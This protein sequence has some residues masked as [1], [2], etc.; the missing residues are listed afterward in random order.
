MTNYQHILI[1][2]DLS[3]ESSI[4]ADRGVA[5]ASQANAKLSVIHVIEP[6]NFAYGGDIPMDLTAIQEQLDEHARGKL[7]EIGTKYQIPEAQQFVIV[8]LPQHEIHRVA[9]DEN[10]DLVVV[11]SHGRHGLSLLFGSTSNGVL[12]GANCDVLAVR[13]QR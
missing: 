12:Q 5:I 4:V 13:V 10:V 9:E 8:G 6:I 3:D 7:R 11:G 1:A 2:V